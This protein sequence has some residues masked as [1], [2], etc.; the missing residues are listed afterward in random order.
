VFDSSRKTCGVYLTDGKDSSRFQLASNMVAVLAR[1]N[2][3]LA[4]SKVSVRPQPQRPQCSKRQQGSLGE[5]M[6]P[7]VIF[8]PT[9]SLASRMS[10]SASAT[11]TECRSQSVG[12][13]QTHERRRRSG[14]D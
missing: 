7:T 14:H 5:S 3:K 2:I 13:S 8:L 1:E 4:D 12:V 6:A 11:I 10:S 9:K